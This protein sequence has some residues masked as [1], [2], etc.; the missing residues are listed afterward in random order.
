MSGNGLATKL[1]AL[2]R[3]Q[4]D[5]ASE[6]LGLLERER[7]LLTEGSPEEIATLV[8][9]KERIGSAMASI[10]ENLLSTAAQHSH[11]HT[12]SGL[13]DCINRN[14]RDGELKQQWA[15]LLRIA[16][17][18]KNLNEIN[19]ATINLKR[20]YTENSLAILHG[21]TTTGRG[22]VYSK[23]GATSSESSSTI[24]NKA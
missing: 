17:N 2:I 10:Q 18:C 7:T 15:S 11:P 8:D 9:E 23:R 4:S 24:I 13:V 21:Q 5:C 19:G 12:D 14:D 6:L 3:Q 20:R 16:E 1:S 22:S